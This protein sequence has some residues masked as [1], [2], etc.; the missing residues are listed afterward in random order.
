MFLGYSLLFY[1]LFF[2]LGV[3][4]TVLITPKTLRK[5]TVF[6]SPIVGYCFSSFLSWCLSSLRFKGTDDYYYWVI[7]LALCL[8]IFATIK[9]WR[10]RDNF[11]SKD[12]IIPLLISIVA[13]TII[14]IPSLI[15]QDMSCLTIGNHD[16]V[17]FS[18]ISRVAKESSLN[19]QYLS[20]TDFAL[21]NFSLSYWGAS[22][23]T[24]LFCSVTKLDPYQSQMISLYI[25]FV[26][27]LLL[28]YVVAKEIFLYTNFG[29]NVIVVLFGLSSIFYSCIYNG[30]ERQ[31][32]AV[33]VI[34]LFFMINIL[35]IRSS[36][37][38]ESIK[39]CPL[40]LLSFWGLFIT[41]DFMI[42]IT[43]GVI[44][45]Y[46]VFRFLMNR[47]IPFYWL[48][49]NVILMFF[50]W[51]AIFDVSRYTFLVSGAYNDS[52][53]GWFVR[54]IS[55]PKL[56]GIA[57]F[58]KNV[59]SYQDII[60]LIFITFIIIWGLI[61]LC[62]A[63]REVFSLSL[64]IFSSVFLI[65]FV[66]SYNSW[67]DGVFGSYYQMK[68]FTTFLPLLLLS[69][70]CIFGYYTWSTIKRSFVIGIL[71]LLV[72]LNGISAGLFVFQTNDQARFVYPETIQLK[73]ISNSVES[74]NISDGEPWRILWEG[75]FLYPRKV[76]YEK[77]QGDIITGSPLIGEWSLIRNAPMKS[78]I[79]INSVYSLRETK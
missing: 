58:V 75:Y 9:N 69:S 72:L 44:L 74:V 1:L 36:N 2:F 34:L 56:F 40:L 14:A 52:I 20:L 7:L 67:G 26:I 31:I 41:Y 76:Y 77:T 71:F 66:V 24:A 37:W 43:Y 70:L 68:L 79:Y 22:F 78:D 3:G 32:I 61:K 65:A 11:F 62:K 57:S 25:F 46:V 8:L 28:S 10:Q 6:L 53:G 50:Y 29:S 49:I 35:I 55:L 38:R 19:D 5:Y 23:N 59:V 60:S 64:S 30:F 39:Y 73:Q 45:T 54:W 48:I 51:V 18:H 63:N 12:L 17:G 13:F 15:H 42:M 21:N 16:L 27:A 33:S 47:M 4:L